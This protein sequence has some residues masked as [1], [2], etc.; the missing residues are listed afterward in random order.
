MDI[1]HW[2]LTIA[3]ILIIIDGIGSAW[4]PANHHSLWFDLERSL[5][6]TLGVVLLYAG[7]CL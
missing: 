2:L 3:G 4:L 5:R 6:A 7:L 1:I